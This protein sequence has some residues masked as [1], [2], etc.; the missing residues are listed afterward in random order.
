[1][2]VFLIYFGAF[3]AIMLFTFV[4]IYAMESISCYSKWDAQYEPTYGVF[5]DCKIK[6]D[7]KY[8]PAS[9]YK[10]VKS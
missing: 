5:S 1:M 2:R 4:P 9:A 6:V 8:I 3:L 10:I 7:G